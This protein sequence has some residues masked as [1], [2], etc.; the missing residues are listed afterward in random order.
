M[1]AGHRESELQPGTFPC[2]AGAT[3]DMGGSCPGV[4]AQWGTLVLMPTPPRRLLHTGDLPPTLSED[5]AG[6]TT[7]SLPFCFLMAS[8]TPSGIL[9]HRPCSCSRFIS[10]HVCLCLTPSNSHAH[11]THSA[12]GPLHVLLVSAWP[13]TTS[14]TQLSLL[15]PPR[16]PLIGPVLGGWGTGSPV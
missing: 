16:K 8:L 11:H 15:T 5:P 6:Q 13:L 2:P 10:F 14:C 4:R 9:T 3:E 7:P 1:S 12:S